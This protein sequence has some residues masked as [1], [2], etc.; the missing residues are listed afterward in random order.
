MAAPQQIDRYVIEQELGKGAFGTVYRARH[1]V[2]GRAV[3]LKV[4]LAKHAGDSEVVERFFREARAAASTRSPH[5]VDVL[6]ASIAPDGTPFL[7]LELLDGEDLDVH[8]TRQ[9]RL[10]TLEA[11]RFAREMASGLDAAHR[12]GIVH[13]DL[14]P[15]N[16]FLARRADGTLQAKIL[17]FGMS[18]LASPAPGQ[19]FRTGTGAIMG[20]PLYMA[21]EQL[22]GGARDVDARA[23]IYALGAMLFQMLTGR[24][25]HDAS[26]LQ[27][28]LSHKLTMPADDV[29]TVVPGLPPALAHLVR[30]CLEI[31]P[32]LRPSTC[33]EIEYELRELERVLTT[34]SSQLP[35]SIAAGPPP[36]ATSSFAWWLLA[37]LGGTVLTSM[38]LAS[39]VMLGAGGALWVT[40]QQPPPAVGPPTQPT[41]PAEQTWSPQPA[42]PAQPTGPLSPDGTT[43]P[44]PG[45]PVA[46]VRVGISVLGRATTDAE[47]LTAEAAYTALAQCRTTRRE[48]ESL[49]F[50]WMGGGFGADA[51]LAYVGGNEFET[52]VRQCMVDAIGNAAAARDA[53]GIVTFR[54]TLDPLE[55]P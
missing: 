53:Q 48:V 11:V 34:P 33:A 28:L 54:V 29:S 49:R 18:K 47:R 17:D 52:P 36:P 45:G 35:S 6:D 3:A 25:P 38:C 40:T 13:R 42:Q 16:I 41:S 46:G 2:T 24:P 19:S 43:Q 1:A 7:A 27:A 5:I 21:P 50:L 30:R 4:L 10:R 55:Q 26:T 51:Q 23:D 37:L 20:T 39:V 12:H 15:A 9:G 8:L 22:R 32:E 14:K 44:R 31:Q